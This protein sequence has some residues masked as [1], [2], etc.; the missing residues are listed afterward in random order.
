MATKKIVFI[1]IIVLGLICFMENSCLANESD[2][3]NSMNYIYKTTYVW[4]VMSG[5][6]MFMKQ[7]A[8][9]APQ[10]T[11]KKNEA[12]FYVFL[13]DNYNFI[14]LFMTSDTKKTIDLLKTFTKVIDDL[15]KDSANTYIPIENMCIIASRKL[16]GEPIELLLGE[17]RKKTLP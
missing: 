6:S 1:F 14:N 17:L 3:W 4:G 16:R 15:Y 7:I 2:D 8:D 9:C 11:N 5:V 10:F 12:E 13:E